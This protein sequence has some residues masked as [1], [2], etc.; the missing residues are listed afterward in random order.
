MFN[1]AVPFAD[2]EKEKTIY[3]CKFLVWGASSRRDT[4]ETK[5]LLMWKTSF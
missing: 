2:T 4:D 1:F 3:N 5:V